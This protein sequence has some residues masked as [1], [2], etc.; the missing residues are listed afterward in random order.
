MDKRISLVGLGKLGLCLAACYAEAG[1][2]VL[3]V[4]IEERVV[5][6][7]NSAKSPIEEPGLAELI[8]KTSGKTLRATTHHAEA[9]THSDITVVLV[10]TPSNPDGSFS[11]RH[12]EAALESLAT[13][14]KDSKKPYHLF[15]ISSTVMPGST[16]EKFIPIIEH[17]SKRK[18]GNGFDVA[19][20]PDFV[21]LGRVI[22]GFKKPD[23]VVIG[24]TSKKAGRIVEE[25]HSIMCTNSPIMSHM[26]IISAELAKVCLNAYITTKISFANS[27]AN[28]CESIPLADVDAI[29]TTIGIDKRISPYYFRGGLGFGG[30]CFPRDTKAYITLGKINGIQ[31]DIVDAAKEV[32]EYQDEH[33]AEIVLKHI[34]I[35]HTNSVGIMGLS[36]VPNTPVITESPAIKLI[37]RLLKEDTYIIAY[38]KLAIPETKS[39]IGS[40][41]DYVY[42]P[43]SLLEKVGIVV[44]THKDAD[45]ARL[46]EDFRPNK[47][48][49]VIDCWRIIDRSKLDSK[50]YLKQL[51][52]Y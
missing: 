43:D 49:C 33:L 23:M 44:L 19:Y 9:I 13:A 14:L 21:A 27:V 8:A 1:I 48:M 28:L 11:N 6:Y 15:V 41:I 51:G 25:L 16:M 12:I 20:D 45:M 29:T 18:L 10:A 4:D 50:I 40:A 34:K 36:F 52:K 32:N 47:L 3:G 37:K 17:Y 30:T 35:Y 42:S 24:E 7:V 5:D 26:N 46:I 38:D 31:T 22:E 39:A 2:D